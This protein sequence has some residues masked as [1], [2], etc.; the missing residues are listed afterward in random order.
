MI[1]NPLR[2]GDTCAAGI[3]ARRYLSNQ[4]ELDDVVGKYYLRNEIFRIQLVLTKNNN[5]YKN[6]SEMKKIK[7]EKSDHF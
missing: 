7:S 6:Y 3:F 2:T 5:L 1:L 4:T